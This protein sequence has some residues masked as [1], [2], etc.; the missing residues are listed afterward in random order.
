VADVADATGLRPLGASVSNFFQ[1][2]ISQ[3]ALLTAGRNNCQHVVSTRVA[4]CDRSSSR[5]S[6]GARAND[7]HGPR[8]ALIRHCLQSLTSYRA[9]RRRDDILP[10]DR[11]A[12]DLR[13]CSN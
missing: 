2:V 6:K 1:P 10:S 9:A 5:V 8:L 7:C 11:I 4:G 13:P 3:W 12:A